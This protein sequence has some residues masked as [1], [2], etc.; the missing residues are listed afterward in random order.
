MRVLFS[1]SASEGHFLPLVPLA[2][3]F[4]ER[5]DDVVFATAAGFAARVGDLGFDVLPAGLDNGQLNEQYAPFRARL[6]E[7]PFDDRRPYA[8]TWRFAELDAPAKLDELHARATAG[9]PS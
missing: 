5:G 8:L 7:I 9:R 4:A 2:R 3:A 6:A 1:C